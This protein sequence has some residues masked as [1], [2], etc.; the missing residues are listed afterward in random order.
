M[1]ST[2]LVLSAMKQLDRSKKNYALCAICI[3]AGQDIAMVIE[4]V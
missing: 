4:K 3:S 2:R 1:S